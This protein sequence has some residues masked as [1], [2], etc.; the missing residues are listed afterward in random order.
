EK[1]HQC[2]KCNKGFRR[3][4]DLIK[5]LWIHTSEMPL[6]VRCSECEK[7]LDSSPH[8][9]RQWGVYGEKPSVCSECGQCC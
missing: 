8:D 4:S 2:S 1:H 6:N 5:H 9:N 3:C 7:Y